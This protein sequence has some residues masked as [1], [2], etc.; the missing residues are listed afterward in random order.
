MNL[1]QVIAPIVSYW[2]GE[3]MTNTCRRRGLHGLWICFALLG[4][5]FAR[6]DLISAVLEGPSLADRIQGTTMTFSRP[7]PAST[8]DGQEVDAN[9]PRFRQLV[10]LDRPDY[11]LSGAGSVNTIVPLA[12]CSGY[13][14]GGTPWS[15][16]IRT[17]LYR[18]RNGRDWEAVTAL[19]DPQ[20]IRSIYVTQ[21]N[22]MLVATYCPVNT[23]GKIYVFDPNTQSL[24]RTLTMLTAGAWAEHWSWGE[25]NGVLYVGEY[26]PK[27]LP[28]NAR[29]IYQSF[30]GGDTWSVFV[31]RPPQNDYHVHKVLGDPYRSQLYWSHGDSSTHLLTRTSDGGQTWEDLSQ[32]EQ[33]TAGVA[34]P[35]AV[36]FGSDSGGLGIYRFVAGAAEPEP[37]C[38]DPLVGETWDMQDINGV[39]YVTSYASYDTLPPC[40][41]VSRDGVHWG[42][43]YQWP[44]GTTGVERF[45]G[46]GNG[47]IQTTF[48]VNGLLN[49]APLSFPEPVVR[50][51]WGVQ[52]DRPVVNLLSNP[53]VS[54]FENCGTPPWSG[55]SGSHLDCTTE[56]A[57]SGA[58]SLKVTNTTGGPTLE[59]VSPTI[60]GNFPS[61][62]YVTATLRTSGWGP[63]ARIWAD[64][65]D[66]TNGLRS[67]RDNRLP[68][69]G[70]Q[71]HTPSLRLTQNSQALRIEVGNDWPSPLG[72]CFYID[73]VTLAVQDPPLGFQMGGEPRAGETLWHR[74]PFPDEW[75][76]LFCWQTPNA[77]TLPL[78]QSAVLKAWSTEDGS[79]WL[80]LV[81]DTAEH[82]LLQEVVSGQTH[83][84]VALPNVDFLPSSLNRFAVVRTATSTS[85]YD[86][87]PGGLVGA[88]GGAISIQPQRVYFG[89]TPQG[90]QQAGGL[91]SNA[92]VYS[93]GLQ[94]DE[95]AQ[96]FKAIALG[97]D[98]IPQPVPPDGDGDGVPD[99]QD[100]CPTVWNPDQADRDHDGVGDVCDNCPNVYNP[101]QADADQD[102]VGD[103]CDNCPNVENPD[104]TDSDGDGLGDACDNCPYTANPDQADSDHD[105][106]GDACDN[107]PTTP[108]PDQRDW[109]DD[110]LG[111]ACDNCPGSANPD[112]ADSD[113]DGV[114]DACDNC[115]AKVNPDQA[116]S[117]HDG[118]G[119]ACDQCP[120]TPVGLRVDPTGCAAAVQSMRPDLDGDVDVD[121]TDFGIF[122]ACFN[123][124]NRPPTAPGCLAADFDRDSDVDLSD[125]G[126]FQ[127]CFNGPN[128]PP[129]CHP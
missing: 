96:A 93:T 46:L 14:W 69:G 22:R 119:D 19:G 6:A 37:C 4:T 91:Y 74:I 12:Y 26:G 79:A 110:G 111:D 10:I 63:S 67:S 61:G 58:Q 122:Q 45:A 72:D 82:F 3:P 100:N 115:P 38:S 18:S 125:F 98:P 118:V 66:M 53:S 57:H 7:S 128:R 83:T 90:T 124:P 73:S 55:I 120:G 129:A 103:A 31:D 88:T 102:G 85:L 28:D 40:V 5:G 43:L 54:S 109:D 27:T 42:V 29:R 51:S 86:L 94:S 48:T 78:S 9:T 62:S 59:A 97:Q 21:N 127:A 52:V 71:R 50:T 87:G 64:V 23:S 99:L 16:C 30:D 106:V 65:F 116:D 107:C 15:S 112:Q 34:R 108:N 81:V 1:Q 36:Y 35:D 60:T 117:D 39:I 95:I 2:I 77:N 56:R 105:G 80:Q 101:D 8:D 123:G 47:T 17:N 104:Q 41:A 121:L 113:G 24:R 84:L 76:D 25:L 92:R 33:P 44:V 49:A 11:T 89:S 126:V 68:T 32:K 75:T 13:F 114:G 70:W 20:R